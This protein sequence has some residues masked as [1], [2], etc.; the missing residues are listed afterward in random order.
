M[1]PKPTVPPLLVLREGLLVKP[2]AALQ[3]RTRTPS[4]GGNSASSNSEPRTPPRRRRRSGF[5]SDAQA[6]D[7]LL[8]VGDREK[9]LCDVDSPSLSTAEAEES[10]DKDQLGSRSSSPGLLEHSSASASPDLQLQADA[11]G[12]FRGT[13][14]ASP[15][16]RLVD[17]RCWPPSPAR[18]AVREIVLPEGPS[19]ITS[20]LSDLWIKEI[21]MP[22][23]EEEPGGALEEVSLQEEPPLVP[24]A[25]YRE[26]VSCE[27]FATMA[28]AQAAAEEAAAAAEA[29]IAAIGKQVLPT[30][31]APRLRGG[32][33]FGVPQAPHR[34]S[35]PLLAAPQGASPGPV[36]GPFSGTPSSPLG[37]PVR[38]EQ[39]GPD[40]GLPT[41]VA[42]ALN[43]AHE[44]R[45]GPFGAQS[46]PAATA[47][48]ISE[49]D[50]SATPLPGFGET[51][52]E[53]STDDAWP[54]PVV[55]PTVESAPVACQ[56]KLAAIW[57]ELKGEREARRSLPREACDPSAEAVHRCARAEAAVLELQEELRQRRQL[58]GSGVERLGSERVPLGHSWA[59]AANELV[60][61]TRQR[62]E[63]R[64][65]PAPQPPE[66]P[67][68]QAWEQEELSAICS[69]QRLE[70]KHALDYALRECQQLQQL[71]GRLPWARDRPSRQL[72]RVPGGG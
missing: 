30:A 45:Q 44:R 25:E 47:Y 72:L 3:A 33:H 66:S 12:S 31:T 58:M 57:E 61:A 53:E 62:P 51:A 8:L 28:A 46:T 11:A 55:E 59:L 38:R 67:V 6:S 22:L 39:Q 20:P 54:E 15:R 43:Q 24:A 9:G 19:S 27:H 34:D 4:L 64:H 56:E 23:L 36:A 5:E 69:R 35:S 21:E 29:A 18:S 13:Y 65:S 52:P 16:L 17:G 7:M 49:P 70:G 32:P 41:L 48:P 2:A 37:G 71:A 10:D 40:T 42:P 68:P 14:V 1:S 60:E 63:A 50:T 26:L